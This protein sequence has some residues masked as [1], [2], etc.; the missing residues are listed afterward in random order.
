[1]SKTGITS[2]VGRMGPCSQGDLS[3]PSISLVMWF[4]PFGLSYCWSWGSDPSLTFCSPVCH[5]SMS[6]TPS[7]EKQGGWS[8]ASYN[9]HTGPCKT[10]LLR[11][12]PSGQTRFWPS[13]NNLFSKR[14]YLF[15]FRGR[16]RERGRET[17]HVPEK[18]SSVASCI[19]PTGNWISGHPTHWAT[20]V[21]V[22]TAPVRVRTALNLLTT[23]FW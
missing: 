3:S 23:E 15:I 16:G 19:P 12:K 13:S 4:R 14:F 7:E 18:H 21:R 2:I 5:D 11:F 1:M 8:T 20:P 17:I 6:Q 10:T 22:R 9:F